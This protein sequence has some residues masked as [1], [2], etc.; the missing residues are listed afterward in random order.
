MLKGRQ[1]CELLATGNPVGILKWSC[2]LPQVHS[3]RAVRGAQTVVH[4]A[5]RPED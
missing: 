1:F 4:P 2:P 5:T 3:K